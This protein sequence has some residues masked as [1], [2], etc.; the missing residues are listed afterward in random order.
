MLIPDI[1]NGVVQFDQKPGLSSIQLISGVAIKPMCFWNWCCI[2]RV[3][4]PRFYGK[5]LSTLKKILVVWVLTYWQGLGEKEIILSVNRSKQFCLSIIHYI[6][7]NVLLANDED[8]FDSIY[9]I[10]YEARWKR[11]DY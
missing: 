6:F 7:D 9:Y 5:K 4:M 1:V 11:K 8:I 3:N 2:Q 10:L